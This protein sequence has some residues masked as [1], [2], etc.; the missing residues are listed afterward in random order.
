MRLPQSSL[1]SERAAWVIY[2][3][4][5][6]IMAVDAYA[7]PRY[8]WDFLPYVALVAQ[9]DHDDL[10]AHR[11]AYS[12]AQ[13]KMPVAIFATN[14]VG[15][16]YRKANFLDPRIFAAEL[17]WYRQ[18]ILYIGL[19]YALHLIG[20]HEGDAVVLL[21]ALAYFGIALIIAIWISQHLPLRA[22]LLI[23]ALAIAT[24]PFST[25]A[26]LATPDALF[27][28]VVLLAM[29]FLIESR[30]PIPAIALLFVSILV[31]SDGMLLAV[32]ALVYMAVASPGRV[33]LSRRTAI[34]LA[35]LAAVV[36]LSLSRLTHHPGW[37]ALIKQSFLSKE[38]A[39]AIPNGVLPISVYLNTLT[40]GLHPSAVPPWLFIFLFALG[41]SYLVGKN[42]Q[43]DKW[44]C[45]HMAAIMVSATVLKY[46]VFPSL[47]DRHTLPLDAVFLVLAARM[48]GFPVLRE[49]SAIPSRTDEEP[50]ASSCSSPL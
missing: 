44:L 9:I 21:S 49:P 28:F 25:T 1:V 26:R 23:S 29:Y 41:C 17:S 42:T 31:R 14:T 35:T 5:A 4:L 30:T 45:L 43:R 18:R 15:S 36:A 37:I 22:S 40:A 12:E 38:V 47:E 32:P 3:C 16:E 33:R 48:S 13:R 20:L 34:I 11:I 8:N 6:A 39:Q 2:I 10:S 19:A 46:L 24:I 50:H 7:R 27:T